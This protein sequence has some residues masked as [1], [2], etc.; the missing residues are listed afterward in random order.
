MA[1]ESVVKRTGPV[2]KSAP[3]PI[4]SKKFSAKERLVYVY[5]DQEA[6]KEVV[7]LRVPK[8][9]QPGASHLR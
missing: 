3:Y 9:W 1:G 6:A 5:L 7:F 8:E 4:S 2:T